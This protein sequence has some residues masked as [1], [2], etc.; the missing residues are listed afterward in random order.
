MRFFRRVRK[1]TRNI[2]SRIAETT[3]RALRITHDLA[4]CI[5][6]GRIGSMLLDRFKQTGETKDNVAYRGIFIDASRQLSER[7]EGCRSLGA[8]PRRGHSITRCPTFLGG[9]PPSKYYFG[10]WGVKQ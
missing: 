10:G 1:Y 7:R 6:Q 5:A 8:H 3:A 9:K 2:R 4:P